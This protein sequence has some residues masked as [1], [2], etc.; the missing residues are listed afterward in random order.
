M[1]TYVKISGRLYGGFWALVLAAFMVSFSTSAHADLITDDTVNAMPGW[2]GTESIQFDESN[3]KNVDGSVDY[4]V[5][6]PGKFNLSFPDADPSNGAQYVYRYQLYNNPG[7][8]STDFIRKLTVGL[9]GITDSTGWYCEYIE[10]DPL[11]PSGGVAPTF[12]VQ[13]TGSP[14]TSA[15]W[16]FKASAPV[17]PGS[18]S[19]MLIF[20]SPYGPTFHAATVLSSSSTDVWEGQL[21]S[22]V[23]EPASFISLLILGGLLV[24][25]RA[26]RE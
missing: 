13:L 22:P 7:P 17:N 26:L 3:G 20:T 1:L 4:A 19:K 11:Y 5:Y 23:P 6:A 8:D 14:Y 21:P 10:P 15:V 16:A 24:V 12:Q 25:F 18:Y 9:V 2:Y